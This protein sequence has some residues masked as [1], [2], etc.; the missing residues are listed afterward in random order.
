MYL[1]SY[2]KPAQGSSATA[3][4]EQKCEDLLYCI[5]FLCEHCRP[6]CNQTI[7]FD[8]KSLQNRP[9]CFKSQFVV[10]YIM[11]QRAWTKVTQMQS[12]Y[13][14]SPFYLC[15]HLFSLLHFPHHGSTTDQK[16]RARS[17]SLH[18]CCLASP[19]PR[20]LSSPH[21]LILYCQSA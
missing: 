16:A 3:E 9:L 14:G 5:K 8:T 6:I 1:Y 7:I 18:S 20:D 10:P 2:F 17:V 13:F 15:F 4:K 11:R 19:L 12:I 21:L